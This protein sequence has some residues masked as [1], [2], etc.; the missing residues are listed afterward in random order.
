MA[1]LET[2]HSKVVHSTIT[3]EESLTRLQDRALVIVNVMPKATYDDGHI[4]GSI[5]LPLA[6]LEAQACRVISNLDQEIAVYC[7]GPT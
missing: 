3:R 2:I 7:G 1:K 4:P 6:D 5:N